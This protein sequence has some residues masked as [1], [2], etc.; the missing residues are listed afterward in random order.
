[1]KD[2]K[3]VDSVMKTPGFIEKQ[4]V[5]CG[6]SGCKCTKGK[7]HGPYHYY[8]YWKLHHKVWIQKKTYVTRKQALILEKVLKEYKLT[9]S[10]MGE[11]PYRALRRGI[12][13]N[14]RKGITGMTQ[15]KLAKVSVFAKS[16]K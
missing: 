4:M 9:L 12:K 14:I 1:M 5:S 16:F 15:R 11:N 3:L 8:R 2:I 13:D 6:K 10:L 7:L